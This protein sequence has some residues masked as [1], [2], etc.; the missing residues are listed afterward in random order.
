[1]CSAIIVDRIVR[2]VSK[3][4]YYLGLVVSTKDQRQ[5]CELA[6]A[7]LVIEVRELEAGRS[8]IDFNFFIINAKTR[9][10][11]YQHYHHS[12]GVKKFGELLNLHMRRLGEHEA[13]LATEKAEKEEGGTISNKKRREIKANFQS[14]LTITQLVRHEDLPALVEEM[15]RVKSLRFEIGT[16]K[17]DAAPMFKPVKDVVRLAR[18]ELVFDNETSPEKVKSAVLSFLGTVSGSH[19]R[20]FCEGDDGQQHILNLLDNYEKFGECEFS[21]VAKTMNLKVEDFAN[22]SMIKR[23]LAAAKAHKDV[24]EGA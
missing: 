13:Q 5:V 16:F 8:V 2:A 19:G 7:D 15:K 4:D 11:L 22:S 17:A 12:L 18:T 9:N 3:G 24:F 21:E 6:K 20:L 23:L 10:G 14:K 1:M